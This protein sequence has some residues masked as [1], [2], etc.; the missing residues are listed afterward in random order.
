MSTASPFAIVAVALGGAFIVALLEQAIVERRVA[1][2]GLAGG[3]LRTLRQPLTMPD[4]KDA[5]L[6]HGAPALLLM[7]AVLGLAMVPWTPDFRGLD[8]ESGAILYSAALAYVTPAVFMAGWGSGRPLQVIGGF[9]FLALMLAFEMPIVMAVTAAAAPP[10]SLRPTSIV[11]AQ[12]VV[13]LALSQPLAFVLFVPAIM[14]VAFIP[15]FDLPQ[16]DGELGGGAFSSYTGVHAALV[17]LAQKIL[18]LGAAAMT[19]TLFLGGWQGPLLPPAVWMVLKTAAVVA[20]MLYAGRRLPR[21]EIDRLLPFAW[22]IAIPLA[23]LAIV[24]SGLITLLFY[25]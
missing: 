12:D 18:L 13:P 24:W 6:F 11:E 25:R 22:K 19:V 7:G 3:A 5:W 8:F 21:V 1:P 17:W 20:V 2:A 23:I 9:R 15:P 14:A 4:V 10:E 16:A